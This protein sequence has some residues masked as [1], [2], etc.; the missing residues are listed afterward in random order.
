MRSKNPPHPGGL[1]LRQRIE[2]LGLTH[3]GA[4]AALG[5]LP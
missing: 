5:V 1:V 4:A 3:M 2:P